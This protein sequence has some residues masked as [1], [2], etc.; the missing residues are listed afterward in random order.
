MWIFYYAIVTMVNVKPKIRVKT[1]P[2]RIYNKPYKIL[3]S[4]CPKSLTYSQFVGK[5]IID[6]LGTEVRK[7]TIP[8]KNGNLK[9][10]ET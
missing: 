6:R 4:W 1:T 5:I 9:E 2:I 7:A 3:Q 10:I 8:D